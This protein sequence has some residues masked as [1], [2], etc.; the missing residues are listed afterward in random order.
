MNRLDIAGQYLKE[1][2]AICRKDNFL[3]EEMEIYKE[4]EAVA[5]RQKDT[6]GE[7]RFR[8]LYDETREKIH[9]PRVTAVILSIL[10]KYE[11][12]K[13]IAEITKVK[14][15]KTTIIWSYGLLV[16]TMIAILCL[17]LFNF[18]R[19]KKWTS[20][21]LLANEMQLVEHKTQLEMLRAKLAE[22]EKSNGEK[23][24]QR[25]HLGKDQAQDLLKKL[26]F[27]MEH[28]QPYL[29]A[30][31]SLAALATQ[32]NVNTAYLSQVINE[33]F[34]RTF[35]DFIN[36][37]RVEAV[38]KA[39]AKKECDKYSILEIALDAGFNSKS[40][41]NRVFKQQTGITPKK[42]RAQRK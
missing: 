27:L 41:F 33:M 19:I 10:R 12:G 8:K 38:K 24:Y 37:F 36:D 15:S 9:G 2:M 14:K 26:I 25:S 18:Q 30:G 28:E 35:N 32:L 39:L 17:L 21:L 23:K 20:Q 29:D 42:Y 7:L 6:A 11:T 4:L 1:A 22:M 16:A 5:A 3:P 40:V 13:L 31:L 34:A